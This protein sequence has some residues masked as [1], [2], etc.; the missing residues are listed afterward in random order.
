MK[1]KINIAEGIKQEYILEGEGEAQRILQ[2]ANSLCESLGSIA[3][4]LNTS[5]VGGAA[6]SKA[7]NLR[8]TEQYLEALSEIL[9]KSSVLLTPKSD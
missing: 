6:E 3:D 5:N 1:S 2:E 9:G 4:A 8:L 7:L